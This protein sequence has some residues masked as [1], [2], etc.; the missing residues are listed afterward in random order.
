MSPDSPPIRTALLAVLLVTSVVAGAVAMTGSAT[1]SLSGATTTDVVGGLS[2]VQ[3]TITVRGQ[4]TE[5]GATNYYE[6]DVTDIVTSGATVTDFSFTDSGSSGDVIGNE[7]PGHYAESGHTIVFSVTEDPMDRDTKL[8]FQVDL[9]LDTTMLR[10]GGQHRYS[11]T[12]YEDASRDVTL[13]PQAAEF[14]VVGAENLEVETSEQTTRA[15][16]VSHEA[17]HT[18]TERVRGVRYVSVHT[19]GA[20]YGNV[21][22]RDV[23]VTKNDGADLSAATSERIRVMDGGSSILVPLDAETT[24][25]RDDSVRVTLHNVSNPPSDSHFTLAFRTRTEKATYVASGR[26]E[27]QAACLAALDTGARTG[28]GAPGLGV[29]GGA[30]AMLVVG[31]VLG[32]RS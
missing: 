16:D 30:A 21:T 18:M 31:T 5:N 20:G 25:H 22:A 1:A 11:V 2:E 15:V 26:F 27:L 28:T 3:Q 7:T 24:F 32:R 4:A 17:T 6:V 14:R 29:L 8:D 13:S 9:T 23:S 19:N 10:T 12:Q